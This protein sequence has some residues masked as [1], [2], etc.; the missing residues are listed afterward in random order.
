MNVSM[1]APDT[2]VAYRKHIMKGF[3]WSHQNTSNKILAK[4]KRYK[5]KGKRQKPIA[6]CGSP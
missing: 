6:F 1:D 4:V 3:I 5:T 2:I